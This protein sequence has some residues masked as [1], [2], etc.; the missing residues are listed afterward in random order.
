[1]APPERGIYSVR[2]IESNLSSESIILNIGTDPLTEVRL[3]LDDRQELTLEIVA[4]LPPI[5]HRMSSE[6][7]SLTLSEIEELPRG[8]NIDL[9]DVLLTLPSAVDG[10]LNQV[11]FRQDHASLQFRIDGVP[12]PDTVSSV[13]SDVI[14]PRMWKRADIILGESNCC[15]D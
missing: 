9:A 2:A 3:T 11:H 12:V 14:S 15:S 1:M 13:F 7:Y 10:A 4:P 6:T 8:N 5:Q